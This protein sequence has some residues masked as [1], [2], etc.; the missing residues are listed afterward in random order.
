MT[1]PTNLVS[2]CSYMSRNMVQLDGWMDYVQSCDSHTGYMLQDMCRGSFLP[3]FSSTNSSDE[4]AWFADSDFVLHRRCSGNSVYDW[5][6]ERQQHHFAPQNK[7]KNN[8]LVEDTARACAD[9]AM[10]T[11]FAILPSLVLGTVW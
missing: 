10:W 7:L 2:D 5:F 3:E 1:P 4:R 9:T 11:N 6:H 8:P